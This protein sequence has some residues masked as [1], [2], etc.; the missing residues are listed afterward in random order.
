MN[1]VAVVDDAQLM[2][3][4]LSSFIDSQKYTVY[5][6]DTGQGAV[7]LL[8]KEHGISTLFLDLVMPDMDGFQVL[9]TI[10]TP[11]F[12]NKILKN[13][14]TLKVILMT[15]KDNQEIRNQAFKLGAAHFISKPFKKSE[16]QSLVYENAKK[17]AQ[18]VD[19][20]VLLAEDSNLTRSI[21]T[22]ALEPFG[23]KIIETNDGDVAY[24]YLK[25]NPGK[26]DLVITDLI[27]ERMNG[28]IFCQK[29]REE[30]KL[31]NLPIIFLTA[32]DDNST[33]LDLFKIGATDYLNKPFIVEELTSR[34]QVHIKSIL[35]NKHLQNT[36]NEQKQLLKLK[37]EFLSVCSHDLRSPLTGILGFADELHGQLNDSD[38]QEMA[39]QITTSGNY[40]LSLIND[41]LDL[42]KS[43]ASKSSENF[44][45]LKVSDI[46]K[47]CINSLKASAKKKHIQLKFNVPKR[48][49]DLHILGEEV[50]L[51]R[52]ITNLVSNSIKFTEKNGLVSL[53]LSEKKQSN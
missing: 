48:F 24:N 22:T 46:I 42:G 49:E 5:E 13:H 41:I 39:M 36:I 8:L 20:T 25:E 52:I 44:V 43:T 19:V 47:H 11:A 12:K 17:K 29:V 30:L 3:H 45:Q 50:S 14:P 31:K 23:I 35:L 37:D 53:Q 9:E 40:L 21:I 6:A 1:K 7:D 26:V 15:S 4:L 51:I 2:R 34:L 27:M 32:V 28:D 16:I 33:V 38:Q 18:F 10:N